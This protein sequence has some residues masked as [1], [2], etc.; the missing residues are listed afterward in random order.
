MLD[1]KTNPMSFENGRA[2]F[3]TWWG[4]LLLQVAIVGVCLWPVIVLDRWRQQ[5]V[6][7]ANGVRLAEVLPSIRDVLQRLITEG[8]QDG[9]AIISL[10]DRGGC[11]VQCCQRDPGTLYVEAH[12]DDAKQSGQLTWLGWK[13]PK[14]ELQNYWREWSLGKPE[15]YES[16]G[17]TILQVFS[18][19]YYAKPDDLVKVQLEL[20]KR[21]MDAE[22]PPWLTT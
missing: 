5:R 6:K 2:A 14:E 13:S 3:D 1:L 8:S 9:F 7:K 19:V 15:C 18:D 20:E 11:F 22:P 16:V 12:A 4:L 10:L 21:D 17:K